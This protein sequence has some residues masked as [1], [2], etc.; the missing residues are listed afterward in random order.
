MQG[1]VLNGSSFFCSYVLLSN[2]SNV[3]CLKTKGTAMAKNA[4]VTV[5]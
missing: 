4:S 5:K 2:V 3:R 1:D